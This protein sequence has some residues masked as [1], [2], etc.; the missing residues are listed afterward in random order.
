MAEKK[1]VDS[2][3]KDK[4]PAML[5]KNEVVLPESVAQ[6]P[7]AA[8][9]Y[10]KQENEKRAFAPSNPNESNILLDSY[11][12]GLLPGQVTFMGPQSIEVTAPG[13]NGK[14][15]MQTFD[16]RMVDPQVLADLKKKYG[17][18]AGPEPKYYAGGGTAGSPNAPGLPPGFSLDAPAAPAGLPPGFT[19]DEPTS[20]DELNN[21][22]LMNE[23]PRLLSGT[24][25]NQAFTLQAGQK[26]DYTKSELDR[27]KVIE[28]GGLLAM[29]GAGTLSRATG[30]IDP[31]T[32]QILPGATVAGDAAAALAGKAGH[33]LL[34]AGKLALPYAAK[35]IGAGG[36]Y[37]IARKVGLLP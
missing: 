5:S 31:F 24:E 28:L 12:S 3:D 4:F 15:E 35:A 26:P 27:D 20:D 23:D 34:T 29:S 32:K 1:N 11:A 7:L 33:G 30:A 25:R 13:K 21:A 10:V 18:T 17:E 2:Y 9:M 36:G 16:K 37:Q 6:N 14:P 8:A 22:R 19:L